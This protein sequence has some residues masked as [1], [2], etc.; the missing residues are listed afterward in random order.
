M[1]KYLNSIKHSPIKLLKILKVQIY[2]YFGGMKNLI[3]IILI[4]LLSLAQK[5]DSVEF[6]MLGGKYIGDLNERGE[7]HGNGV[8][9]SKFG[10]RYEGSWL[11]GVY[12]G[13][14]RIHGLMVMFM[15]VNGKMG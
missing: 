3:L 6:P 7:P 15:K 10:G 11:N 2:S 1:Q 9:V 5:R 8:L 12:N 4:P 14:E 13:I